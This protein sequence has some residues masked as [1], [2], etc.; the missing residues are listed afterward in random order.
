MRLFIASVIFFLLGLQ[1]AY[2]Q[3]EFSTNYMGIYSID[4]T[5]LTTVINQISI[6]NLNQDM[7]ATNY[8]LGLKK[9]EVFDL[10][11]EDPSG[12]LD[13]VE[14][15]EGDVTK[16]EVHL[17]NYIIGEGKTRT[18]TVKYK[19][20]QIATKVGEVWNV[21]IPNT[22]SEL[23]T[24]STISMIIPIE[25]GP[26]IYVSPITSKILE[27]GSN[28]NYVFEGV[29]LG[30]QN[31]TASFGKYQTLNYQIKYQLENPNRF[32][33]D[34]TVALPPSIQN[35]QLVVYSKLLPAPRKTYLDE[36]GNYMAVYKLPPKSKTEVIISGTTR[37]SSQ[38]I[39]L[40]K[41]QTASKIPT[42]LVSAYTNSTNFWQTDDL[43]VRA[44]SN[45]LFNNSHTVAQ[46]AQSIYKFL[47]E[48]YNYDFEIAKKNFVDR[49][50]AQKAL[51]NNGHWGCM[52]FT[53]TFIAITRAMGIPAREINGYPILSN[54]ILHP[55]SVDLKYGDLLHAWPEFYDPYYGWV[56]VDPTWGNTS[57]TDYFSKLDTN[58]FSFVIK[59]LKADYP[60]PAGTYRNSE[61][62]KLV[63]VD[64]AQN[65]N[66]ADFE[67]KFE[68]SKKLNFN[69]LKLIQGFRTIEVT[70]TGKI[71]LYDET[72]KAALPGKKIHTFIK[73]SDNNVKLKDSF[74]NWFSVTI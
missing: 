42:R 59:G 30:N 36:D 37:I 35:S 13:V 23:N 66:L 39:D 29:L 74:G 4:K 26:K 20:R 73:R 14:R 10:T 21:Q 6:T 49:L 64:F 58:H 16:L 44:I 5:G 71:I 22:L 48:N 19:T 40:A 7:L 3:N 57:N 28:I 15:K 46:N 1:Q 67:G 70:N 41:S 24:H 56:Q 52:E 32:S 8:N 65:Q 51:E 53:D 9:L 68:A 54:D 47:V 61:S 72:N 63:Q 25:F 45:K 11:A 12:K 18:I 34:Y 31:I 43:K 60:L 50:G 38:Q 62:E 69:I 33:S 2:A 17:G 55:I 27:D